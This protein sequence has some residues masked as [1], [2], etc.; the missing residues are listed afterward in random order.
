MRGVG[1]STGAEPRA[2]RVGRL[3]AGR[4]R[5][6][7]GLA[8]LL[9]AIPTCHA[10]APANSPELPFPTAPIRLV[11]PFPP[12]GVTGQLAQTLAQRL[13]AQWAAEVRV[14]HWTGDAGNR[15]V[16]AFAKKP[17]DGN[18][19]LLAASHVLV[20]PLLQPGVGYNMPRDFTAVTNIVTTPHAIA[21][22]SSHGAKTLAELVAAVKARPGQLRYASPGVGSTSNLTCQLL[23]S[24]AGLVWQHVPEE[25]GGPAVKSVLEDRS[26]I[27]C[28]PLSPLLAP[29]NAGQ[30]RLLAVTGYLRSRAVP[31]V[32][33]AI[34]SGYPSIVTDLMQGLFVPVGTP[35]ATVSRI[36]ASVRQA[37]TGAATRQDLEKDGHVLVLDSPTQFDFYVKTEIGRW[38]RLLQPS[39]AGG[40]KQ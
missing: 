8:L 32:P 16:A 17:A 38:R 15:G 31:N 25:G 19:M 20:N 12:G 14:E 5:L 4:I 30:L 13:S 18:W 6:G 40:P 33:T 35:P 2:G 1:Y 10:A 28:M 7:L 22:R 3:H 24:A 9:A 34:E 23:E 39:A 29:A 36:H 11:V 21:V 27:I 26:D 37:M